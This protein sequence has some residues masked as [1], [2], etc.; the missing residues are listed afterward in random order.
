MLPEPNKIM[1]VF[2]FFEHDTV[3]QYFEKW[4]FDCL[5]VSST[6]L[7]NMI[8]NLNQFPKEG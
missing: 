3:L 6:H 2:C 1:D 8:V 4:M 5:V 7:K